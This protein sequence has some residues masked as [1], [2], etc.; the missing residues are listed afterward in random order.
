VRHSNNRNLLHI[1]AQTSAID[2]VMLARQWVCRLTVSILCF[3]MFARAQGFP[4]YHLA[5]S[6][7]GDVSLSEGS[8]TSVATAGRKTLA[9]MTDPANSGGSQCTPYPLPKGVS[10]YQDWCRQLSTADDSHWDQI[11][12][13]ASGPPAPNAPLP[14][15]GCVLGCMVGRNSYQRG[16]NWGAG[17]WSGKW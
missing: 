1:R 13:N 17:A 8:S 10:S 15:H 11:F 2:Q 7:G 3:S 6:G 4:G 16:V 12:K 14:L 9:S 5:G